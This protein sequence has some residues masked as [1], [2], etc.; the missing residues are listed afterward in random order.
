MSNANY[1][2]QVC[3]NAAVNN[4]GYDRTDTGSMTSSFCPARHYESG[5]TA[6]DTDLITVSI[7][8]DL[9]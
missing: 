1:S 6:T 2:T 8:G 5:G 7:Q 9:A 3:S 4:N